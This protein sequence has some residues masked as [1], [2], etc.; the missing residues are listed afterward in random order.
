[1]ANRA[2]YA[3]YEASNTTKRVTRGLAHRAIDIVRKFSKTK[4]FLLISFATISFSV[5]R[6]FKA[7]WPKSYKPARGP[8]GWGYQLFGT[9]VRSPKEF[10]IDKI[11]GYMGSVIH[12]VL[13]DDKVNEQGL[14]FLD[15]LFRHPQTHEAG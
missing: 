14:N 10:F 12:E 3:A 4:T 11:R 15:R 1:V 8:G 13:A 7:Y 2:R 6:L 5:Y 9:T